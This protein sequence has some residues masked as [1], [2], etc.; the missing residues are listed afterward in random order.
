MESLSIRTSEEV[1]DGHMKGKAIVALE[2]TVLTHGLPRPQ[3]LELALNMEQAVRKNGAT[4]A[5]VGF[6]DGYLHVGLT[7]AELERLANEKDVYKVGPRDY[8]TVIVKEACG[9]TT[10]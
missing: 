4:P 8:G 1:R 6:L 10:V 7:E 5:T 2:S 3:N 9:G